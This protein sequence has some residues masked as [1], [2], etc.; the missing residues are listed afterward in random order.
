MVGGWLALGQ[1]QQGVFRGPSLLL[2]RFLAGILAGEH[3]SKVLVVRGLVTDVLPL[4]VEL[5]LV[6][7]E[8]GTGGSLLPTSWVLLSILMLRLGEGC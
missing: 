3:C 7:V 8:Q 4:P 6:E 1:E 2:I 5:L